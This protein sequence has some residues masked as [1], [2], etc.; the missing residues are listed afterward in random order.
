[1]KTECRG[2]I[3]LI[4]LFCLLAAVAILLAGC[5]TSA[6]SKARHLEQGQKYLDESK[7][8]EASLEFRNA[9]QI[10]DKLGAAHWGLAQAFEGLQRYPEMLDEM[11]KAIALDPNNFDARLKLGNIYLANSQGRAEIIA[12]SEKLAKEVLQK[13]P[14]NIE[15]HILMAGVY[16]SQKQKDKAFEE[17]N[18]A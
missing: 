18:H 15:G 14:N 7:F 5:T 11:K 2:L 17:L 13:D 3:K 9:I 12:E 10:D 8:Q 1:M 16:Y 4:S 6:H